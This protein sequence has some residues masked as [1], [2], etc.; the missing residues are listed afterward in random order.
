MR[1]RVDNEHQSCPACPTARSTAAPHPPNGCPAWES[2]CRRQSSKPPAHAAQAPATAPGSS[3]RGA[4]RTHDRRLPTAR[5]V[6]RENLRTCA[7]DRLV[8][9]PC[10]RPRGASPH[11]VAV[12]LARRNARQRP[13]RVLAMPTR[14]RREFVRN[15]PFFAPSRRSV[16]LRHRP[17]HLAPRTHADTS[18]HWRHRPDSVTLPQ[19]SAHDLR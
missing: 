17:H 3:P 18:R 2:C 19:S 8:A 14:R 7:A 12:G 15:A 13:Y 9:V 1:K 5:S 4:C 6:H 10:R 16:A 11:M